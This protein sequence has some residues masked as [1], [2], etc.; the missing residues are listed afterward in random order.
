MAFWFAYILTRPVGAS[1]ADWFSAA[2]AAGGV[3]YSKGAVS[4]VLLIAIVILVA[5]RGGAAARMQESPQAA[6][7]RLA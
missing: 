1:F 6:A 4:L 3:G 2:H 5:F 7:N